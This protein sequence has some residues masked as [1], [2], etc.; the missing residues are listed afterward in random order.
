MVSFFSEI[1]S[2]A[3]L[4]N[5]K[6]LVRIAESISPNKYPITPNPITEAQ[7]FNNNTVA[8]MAIFALFDHIQFTIT[9]EGFSNKKKFW[10]LFNLKNFFKF[11]SRYSGNGPQ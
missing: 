3:D 10:K 7:Y 11:Y 1:R 9:P 4:K 2:F 8:L 6:A 5:G